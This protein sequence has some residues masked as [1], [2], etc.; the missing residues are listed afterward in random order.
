[1]CVCVS[2]CVCVCLC[3]CVCLCVSVCVCVSVSVSVCVC[4]HA[5]IQDICTHLR[6]W[7]YGPM[8]AVDP[9]QVENDAGNVW[10]SLYKLEKTF[11]DNPN[12]QKMAKF[13][14]SHMS[15]YLLY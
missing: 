1:M 14:S 3:L 6:M 10:R 11:G 2:V 4:V 13:V 8:G 7:M 15:P 5:C 9:D 12:P